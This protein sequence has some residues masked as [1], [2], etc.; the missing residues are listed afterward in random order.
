MGPS[1]DGYH[2]AAALSVGASGSNVYVSGYDESS[3]DISSE[4]ASLF[5][6]SFRSRFGA[7]ASLWKDGFRQ[8]LGSEKSTDSIAFSVHLSGGEAYTAGVER[9]ENGVRFATLWRG[10]SSM[11]LP[12]SGI[13]A[14]AGA[15]YVS[16]ADIYAADY[17]F[18]RTL[19]DMA[20][21][22]KNG[23]PQRFT[24]GSR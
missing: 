23:Y 3:P 7:A 22:W 6:Y 8:L 16:G 17:E 11:R 14:C 24:N 1:K 19:K 5:L 15:V 21:I 10:T 20:I 2:N 4:T 18:H 9:D 13:G 12:V